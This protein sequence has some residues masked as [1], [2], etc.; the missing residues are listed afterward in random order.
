MD[1]FLSETFARQRMASLLAEADQDRLARTCR[2]A[3]SEL[4]AAWHRRLL[5]PLR[6]WVTAAA[7]RGL[8]AGQPDSVRCADPTDSGIVSQI[9]GAA[10][11]E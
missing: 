3:R 4:G 7:H 11:P 6:G 2:A 5:A 1:P 9:T 10:R 8:D